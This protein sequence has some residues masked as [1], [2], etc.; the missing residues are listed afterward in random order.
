MLEERRLWQADI[1]GPPWPVTVYPMCE[2]QVQK[3]KKKKKIMI[4]KTP[5]VK[6][7]SPNTSNYFCIAK[8]N[9]NGINL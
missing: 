7:A 4:G 6:P 5:D 9:L 2:F 8:D 1:P 3:K